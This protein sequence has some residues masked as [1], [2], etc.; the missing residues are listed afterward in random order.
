M[1]TKCR[2]PP[3]EAI[4]RS[5]KTIFE[6]IVAKLGGDEMFHARRVVL[7]KC[8]LLGRNLSIFWYV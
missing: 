7:E 5:F 4:A 6:L 8:T 1:I 2:W 3:T